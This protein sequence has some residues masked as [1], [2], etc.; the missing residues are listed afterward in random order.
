MNIVSRRLMTSALAVTTLCASA[1]LPD[2]GVERGPQRRATAATVVPEEARV[3]VKLK[4][5]SALV[6]ALSANNS[7]VR[8]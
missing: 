8:G 6:R 5:D 2:A 1:A 4:A 7:A 3:I